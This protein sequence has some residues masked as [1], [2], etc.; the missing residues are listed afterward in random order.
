MFKNY[1]SKPILHKAHCVEESDIITPVE[2]K[3]ATSLLTA[4]DS[5]LTFKHYEPVNVGDYIVYSNDD[6]VYHC[7]TV[8][9]HQSCL[10]S[11]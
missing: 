8:P 11:A 4:A 1:Q 6:D 5:Q 10:R 3:E 9:L 7:T 2:G